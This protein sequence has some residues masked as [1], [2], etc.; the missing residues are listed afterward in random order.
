MLV[1][2]GVAVLWVVPGVLWPMLEAMGVATGL[3]AA[4][5]EPETLA[6]RFD[7]ALGTAAAAVARGIGAGADAI[8]VADDLAGGGGPLVDLAFLRTEVFPRLAELACTA[9]GA[10]V[11]ALLHSDG[12]VRSLMTAIAAAGFAGVH[13]DAGGGSR[14]ES[15]L[16]AARAAGLSMIGGI[17][18]AALAD[19]DTATLAGWQAGSL[20]AV[21]GLLPADDGGVTA[22]AQAAALLRALRGARDPEQNGSA[23]PR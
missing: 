1:A 16:A 9:H 5:L 17:P 18:T 13:G 2:A 19:E 12:D 3:R 15:S 11:P 23:S 4:A 21:G 6:G 22:T 8:V 10:G 20:A 14:V 7:A